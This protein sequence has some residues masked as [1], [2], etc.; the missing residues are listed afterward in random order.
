[1]RTWERT[2]HLIFLAHIWVLSPFA[3]LW[4][5]DPHVARP[6]EPGGMVSMRVFTFSILAY[7]AIRTFLAF[8]DPRWL[9]WQYVYPPIDVFLVTIMLHIG[10]KDPLG[11]ITL[12]YLLPIAEAAGTLN[13]LYAASIGVLS[14][15]GTA[16]ASLDHFVHAEKP[17]NVAF[18]VL[19]L[20]V[21]SSLFTF[22]ARRAAEFRGRAQVAADRNR[23][24][25]EMHD[26]VQAQLIS[27]ASQMELVQH[28]APRDGARA[29]EIAQESRGTLRQ[30]ADEL[31]FLVQRLRSPAMGESFL[32]ALRQYAH[33]LCERFGLA[34]DFRT[35]GSPGVLTAEQENTLFRIAQES[36][37]NIVKHANATTVEVCVRFHGHEVHLSISDDG[38]GLSDAVGGDGHVGLESMAE[39]AKSIG[40]LVI[41]RPNNEKGTRV[42]ATIPLGRRLKASV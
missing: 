39:R 26:G 21:M 4:L 30:A 5:Y 1:M 14:I 42:D 6:L 19:F 31:R 18:R 33:N 38:C 25:L 16:L 12:M 34:L 20:V 27:A 36:L 24:A 13:V 10:D 3:F 29:S 8:K 11:N 9:R 35:E 28:L 7:F 22:L 32:P 37:T 17:Y 41:V 15:V 23:L 40:G 2:W